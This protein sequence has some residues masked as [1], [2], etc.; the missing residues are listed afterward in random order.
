[1]VSGTP[2]HPGNMRKYP[3]GNRLLRAE[4]MQAMGNTPTTVGGV[5][6]CWDFKPNATCARWGK[7]PNAH[8]DFDAKNFHWAIACELMRRGGRKRGKQVAEGVV[9]GRVQQLR[10]KIDAR[11]GGNVR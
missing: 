9:D 2:K 7:R 5:L 4:R 3:E 1:M 6:K 11:M 10:G 8:G